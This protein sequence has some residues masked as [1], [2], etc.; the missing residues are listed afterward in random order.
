MSTWIG[1][2]SIREALVELGYSKVP[3]YLRI[4]ALG[5]N[6]SVPSST[7]VAA[8]QDVWTGGG[9]YPLIP[10]ARR[11]RARCAN[12]ND[13][14]TGTGAGSIQVNLLDDNYNVIAPIS[15]TL[16]GGTVDIGTVSTLALRVQGARVTGKGSGAAY[17]ATNIGDIFIEDFDAPN[18]VRAI[19]QAGYGFARQAV[20]TVPAGFTAQIVSFVL[21]INRTSGG[22]TNF[23]TVANHIRPQSGAYF[24]PLELPVD[25]EPYRHDGLPGIPVVEKTDFILRC[26]QAS[27]TLDLTAG[28]L[29]VLMR[30]G[31]T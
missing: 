7:S 17:S 2:P 16:N 25:G 12:V 14:S 29:G 20:F 6:P 23:A 22:V 5:N 8:P 10:S 28:I 4:T 19:L 1:Q 11:L 31:T 18:T 30:N 26:T 27:A 21:G 9:V 24:M 15:V 13:S 3:G